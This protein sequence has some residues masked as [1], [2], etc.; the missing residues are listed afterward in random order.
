MESKKGQRRLL[1]ALIGVLLPVV[2]S[3]TSSFLAS[4]GEP[5]AP[6]I[7]SFPLQADRPSSAG[8]HPS[9]RPHQV[10]VPVDPM[11][12]SFQEALPDVAETAASSGVSNQLKAPEALDSFEEVLP[13]ADPLFQE[14]DLKSVYTDSRWDH[15][16]FG[17][18]F[19]VNLSGAQSPG[20]SAP[21][22][23]KES[24]GNDGHNDNANET[25]T[26]S[27]SDGV[28]PDPEPDPLLPQETEPLVLEDPHGGPLLAGV[29]DSENFATVPEPHTIF[30]LGLGLIGFLLV[31]R[32]K[33]TP[34]TDFDLKTTELKTEASA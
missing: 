18:N 16:Y 21:S 22:T 34:N 19:A 33:K 23:G 32:K 13:D 25:Q 29:P 10:R 2:W 14:K 24:H 4:E 28:P 7:G 5:S 8:Q 26:G 17:P 31:N 11:P 12:S 27:P 3:L 20:G 30:F 1:V 9:S 6:S 15:P